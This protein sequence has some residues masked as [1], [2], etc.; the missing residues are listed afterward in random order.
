M[1]S[2]GGSSFEA[3][4][5]EPFRPEAWKGGG[6]KLRVRLRREH[7]KARPLFDSC[8]KRAQGEEQSAAPIGGGRGTLQFSMKEGDVVA[9]SW[10]E[11]NADKKAH[12]WLVAGMDAQDLGSVRLARTLQRLWAQLST[13]FT[14][15]VAQELLDKLADVA[16]RR[17]VTRDREALVEP[18][19]HTKM[20]LLSSSPRA[21]A[22][23]SLVGLWCLLLGRG[24][25]GSMWYSD[26]AIRAEIPQCPEDAEAWCSKGSAA[27]RKEMEL[28]QAERSQLRLHLRR[29][30]QQLGVKGTTPCSRDHSQCTVQ[31]SCSVEPFAR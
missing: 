31:N 10:S 20:P 11:N 16:S 15:A 7:T 5:R 1:G 23:T 18:L 6:M 2:L 9:V 25:E 22:M 3:A 8:I 19:C 14:D 4:F 26:A 12:K 17:E 27:L 30:A 24:D 21:I 28:R 29:Y 13:E